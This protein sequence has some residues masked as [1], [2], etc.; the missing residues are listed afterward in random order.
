MK[1]SIKRDVNKLIRK[2]NPDLFCKIKYSI[3]NWINYYRNWY[4]IVLSVLF[5]FF[6]LH[7]IDIPILDIITIKDSSVKALINNRT[8]NIVTM[9]SVTFAII[10]FLIAN[11]AIKESFT[12]NLLF[13]KS[14]FFP[15]IFIALSL[16][17]CFIALSTFCDLFPIYYQRNALLVGTYL[18]IFIV[19]LIGYLFTRLVRFTNQNYILEL[20]QKELNS[21]SK[22]NLL[23]LGQTLISR[24]EVKKL[25]L[26]QYS[27]ASLKKKTKGNF[28]L[29]SEHNI[30]TDIKIR[31]LRKEIELIEDKN[32]I[33][34]NKLFLNRQIISNEDG[35]FFV[36]EDE[37]PIIKQDIDKLN[38]CI[39]TSKKSKETYTEA[40]EYVLQKL[41]ENIKSNND[42]LVGSY[43]DMLLEVYK[44][45]QNFK[46]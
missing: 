11:L 46:V 4:Y 2:K 12:Y 37:N 14:G 5:V 6:I 36:N 34:I 21:E 19:L 16:I 7:T 32:K 17:T 26:N 31:K 33:F 43:L 13:K 20:V 28:R 18:I 1:D 22:L 30:V 29:P 25:G 24:D 44:L 38:K 9:I 42:K 3:L 8:N 23:L 10:G 27:I 45:Q 15:I 40:K 35:F 41:Q 39:V